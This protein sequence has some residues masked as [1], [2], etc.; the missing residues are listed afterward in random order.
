MSSQHLPSRGDPPDPGAAPPRVPATAGLDALLG[1]TQCGAFTGLARG[2]PPAAARARDCHVHARVGRLGVPGARIIFR[3]GPPRLRHW[4][5]RIDRGIAYANSVVAKGGPLTVMFTGSNLASLRL[6]TVLKRLRQERA[7]TQEQV[8]KRAQ[9]TRFYVSQ[10]E[11][12]L[13]K[14]PSL[15]VLKRLAK[16][17]GVP[18]TALLE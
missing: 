14:G 16:A 3:A 8:A 17:L 7:L 11:T 13:R 15:A 9:V 12:G 1:R 10:L 5:C 18:V 4:L 2:L 6:N